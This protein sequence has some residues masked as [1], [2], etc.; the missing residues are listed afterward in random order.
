MPIYAC[1][2]DQKMH[3]ADKSGTPHKQVKNFSCINLRACQLQ[4]CMHQPLCTNMHQP[5]H[6][7]WRIP[8]RVWQVFEHESYIVKSHLRLE[9]HCEKLAPARLFSRYWCWEHHKI[10][11]RN[12]WQ[13]V[14]MWQSPQAKATTQQIFPLQIRIVW[15]MHFF[16]TRLNK[17]IGLHFRCSFG[18]PLATVFDM[19][20]QISFTLLTRAHSL[21]QNYS[22]SI[23]SVTSRCR[24]Q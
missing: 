22:N 11:K 20:D 12:R 24:M 1:K 23:S 15:R 7:L 10:T 13:K 8:D 21:I 19:A 5:L 16:L 3:R 2:S 4:R 18:S 6:K 17:T 14:T 9:C